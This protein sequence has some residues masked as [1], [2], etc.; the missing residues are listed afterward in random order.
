[1][2]DYDRKRFYVMLFIAAGSRDGK[3]SLYQRSGAGYMPG[4]FIELNKPGTSAKIV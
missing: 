3:E 1:M 4:R 2:E